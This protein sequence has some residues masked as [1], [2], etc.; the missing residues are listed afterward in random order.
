VPP[1]LERDKWLFKKED[2]GHH[3]ESITT[4]HAWITL[5]NNASFR[6]WQHQAE[7]ETIL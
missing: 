3:Q 1:V 4:K 2:S 5:V 6:Y 7:Q